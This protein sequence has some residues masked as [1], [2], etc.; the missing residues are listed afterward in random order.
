MKEINTQ[1]KE[2]MLQKDVVRLNVLRALKTA[3]GNALSMKGRVEKE[4]SDDEALSII[5][6]QVAQRVE[7]IE[8]YEKAG[9]TESAQTE[10]AEQVILEAMLPTAMSE[11]ELAALVKSAMT[12]TQ[13][14]CKRDM[15]RVIAIVKAK[16]EGRAD[17]KT[18]SM[19][20]ATKISEYES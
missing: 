10:R 8:L 18:I 11:T 7:S 20:V 5:R 13:A 1:I 15:G 19:M 6:K 2:A 3:F 17:P 9:R 12:E 14:T 4:L 16:A